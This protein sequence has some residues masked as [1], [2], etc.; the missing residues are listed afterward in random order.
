[1]LV[2]GDAFSQ[3]DSGVRFEWGATGVTHLAADAACL[4]VV[5][6]LSFTTP[7][8][9][10]N[11]TV[12]AYRLARHGYGTPERPIAVIAAGEFWPGGT[13]R[14][15]VEDLLGADAII[16][17]LHWHDAR[18]LSAEAAAARVC[19]EE[20]RDVAQA[21]TDSPSGRELAAAGFAQD[22]AIAIAIAIATEHDTSRVVPLLSDGAFT[23]AR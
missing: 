14:P 8:T 10:A 3:A 23:A 17:E 9:V 7:V 4:V 22:I 20:V 6:V 12:V 18:R 1:M 2:K 19:F 13:L 21:V 11:A 5:Y 16:S 15:A